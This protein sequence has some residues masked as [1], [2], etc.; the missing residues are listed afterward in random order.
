MVLE[1]ELRSSLDLLADGSLLA[2]NLRSGRVL[3]DGNMG[4]L[5]EVSELLT[6][7]GLLPLRELLLEGSRV[8]FLEKIVVLLNVD[9]EDVL[10]ML[11][12]VEILLGLLLLFD[13]ATLLLANISLRLDHAATGEAS[14]AVRDIEATITGTL[15]G[16]EDSASG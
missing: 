13:T 2:G 12:S 9:T 7:E 16:T 11:L 1:D 10:E 14:V 15:H 4:S 8:I 6:L 3:S 5:V